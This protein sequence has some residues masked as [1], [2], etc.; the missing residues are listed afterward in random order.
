M[1]SIQHY[2]LE[3]IDEEEQ[4]MWHAEHDMMDDDDQVVEDDELMIED[5]SSMSSSPS[6]PDEN[7]NFDLVYAL[8]T[9]VA[10]VEGQAS[11]GKGDALILMEDTNIYWWL[12]EVLKTR[13]VG[14][15]PAENI[16]TPY[17]R[18]ARLNKHRNVEITSPSIQDASY[19]NHQSF[20][21]VKRVTIA[22]DSALQVF[23][24]EVESDI[25]EED[26]EEH[27][28]EQG[29]QDTLEYTD[30]MQESNDNQVKN[31][32]EWQ[33]KNWE[34]QEPISNS[35][36][37]ETQKEEEEKEE[38]QQVLEEKEA[39]IDSSF[40]E[41]ST[42]S[43]IGNEQDVIPSSHH[44]STTTI[45]NGNITELRVFAGNIGQGPLFQ[46][47][48]VNENTTADELVNAAV[49]RFGIKDVDISQD[50]TIEYYIAVQGLDGEDYVLSAQDKPQSIFKTLTDSLTTPMPSLSHI[51]R[52]SQQSLSSTLSV[53]SSRRPRSSSFSNYE[54]TS[55]DEDS[56]IRF[57]LHRRIKR[58]HG[59]EGL[60]Y[61]KV[62][63]Y[64][65]ETAI[66]TSPVQ[67]QQIDAFTNNPTPARLKKH[68]KEQQPNRSEID[69]I[70]KIIPIRLDSFVGT[71]INTALEKFHVP[72][73][74]AENFPN[75]KANQSRQLTRYMLLMR[76]NNQEIE[77]DPNESMSRVLSQQ[78]S[79]SP[80]ATAPITSDLLFVLLRAGT[81][82]LQRTSQKGERGTGD[83]GGVGIGTG[84]GLNNN[85]YNSH[86]KAPAD[87][88]IPNFL[89][90]EDRRPS[91]L[92]ILM[93][94][95]RLVEQRR[96]SAMMN[97][98]LTDP[99]S[100]LSEYDKKTGMTI[101]NS[102]ERKASASSTSS[103]N[104]GVAS[105]QGGTLN[106]TMTNNSGSNHGSQ[107]Q[108][109]HQ[110]YQ[111]SPSSSSSSSLFPPINTTPNSNNNSINSRSPNAFSPPSILGFR[112]SSVQSSSIS[113]SS[114][115][116]DRPITSESNIL[117]G[118]AYYNHPSASSSSIMARSHSAQP[119]SFVPQSPISSEKRKESFK[120]QLKRFVGW[121]SKQKKPAP[122]NTNTNDNNGLNPNYTMQPNSATTTDSPSDTH[123]FVSAPST[124]L[125]QTPGTPRSFK[126]RQLPY[127]ADSRI[128]QQ[129][130]Q[131]QSPKTP[132]QEA[133]PLPDP[134][135]AA[136]AAA[137]AVSAATKRLSTVSSISSSSIST[138]E[139]SEQAQQVDLE[140]DSEEEVDHSEKQEIEFAH[141]NKSEDSLIPRTKEDVSEIQSQY[142]MWMNS[143]TPTEAS[144]SKS[145]S[146]HS[147][148][149][150]PPSTP[151]KNPLRNNK[152]LVL[153][154]QEQNNSNVMMTS[155]SNTSTN[156]T[157]TATSSSSALTSYSSNKK[158][159]KPVPEQ[160]HDLDDLFLLVAHGVDFLTD[161]ENSKWEEEGGYEFHPW[162]RPQ[163]SFAVRQAAKAAAAANKKNTL[164]VEFTEQLSVEA[165]NENNEDIETTS[166]A[167]AMSLLSSSDENKPMSPPLTP[168]TSNE[169]QEEGQ[170]QES[171]AKRVLGSE[172]PSVAAQPVVENQTLDDDELQRIV[173]SH[174]VF[175]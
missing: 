62:S 157:S 47:I 9:F 164:P 81:K 120:Q 85:H 145:P 124:P 12:V 84:V 70:D 150:H 162:N 57:Y 110:Q 165:T 111:Q 74:E 58:A 115:T 116:D 77:L 86:N 14:Y 163:S 133:K 109:H 79:D 92:D 119:S 10:T 38:N 20:Q 65:D 139:L 155:L 141:K 113:G 134:S 97:N 105:S 148:N 69:R 125:P 16:E 39:I 17:E 13:E 54:Q 67:Q 142:A 100:R 88:T 158:E 21:A 118:T 175:Y 33:E 126:S 64:P 29:D 106:I 130:Q 101:L 18:L 71:V 37:H 25:D 45:T 63:L 89:T 56:V 6:I 122:L 31:Q 174:I 140:E 132:H 151:T 87:L 50:T 172:K 160:Q 52:I 76:R 27:H 169:Q 3:E 112:R 96:P 23:H 24:Y 149:S 123:H 143:Q 129:Q 152:T 127:S 170:S 46:S 51:K 147:N 42:D 34:I 153:S 83:E 154:E 135:A 8:H 32:Q 36:I 121:G 99:M 1:Y 91:I 90:A 72:D 173:A 11:V 156:S 166:A 102:S 171:L 136:I 5:S 98:V 128:D 131:E 146:V 80:N 117:D 107:Q 30:E 138:E 40:N 22:E 35:A 59:Q 55:F 159:E 60:M 103:L 95:P 4:M 168:Q 61:I 2:P 161:K 44:I 15:I 53:N 94:S 167:I 26:E 108:H 19:V 104:Q 28:H 68:R 78:I 41:D 49:D 137:A 82:H 66:A 93:D 114:S 48:S 73:A 144:E 43:T 75:A 7:I